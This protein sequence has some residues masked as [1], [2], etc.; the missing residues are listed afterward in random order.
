MKK[1]IS[2]IAGIAV[3][4]LFLYCGMA[5]K[6]LAV[7]KVRMRAKF[8]EKKITEEE[9]NAFLREVTLIK[10]M[11]DPKFVFSVD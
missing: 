1:I 7:Q 3:L 6:A 4:L 9:Y 10:V 8:E 11:Q 5:Q 2:I